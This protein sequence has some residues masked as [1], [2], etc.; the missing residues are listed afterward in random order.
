MRAVIVPAVFA[1]ILVV[2][3]SACGKKTAPMP[4]EDVPAQQQ[5]PR[6]EGAR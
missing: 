4:P 6:R 3:L 5:E 2:T 1:V